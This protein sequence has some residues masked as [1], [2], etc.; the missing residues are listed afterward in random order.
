MDDVARVAKVSRAT[1]SRVLN[2]NHLVEASTRDRVRLAMKEVG[3]A[4]SKRRSGPKPKNARPSQ[5]DRGA[6]A[7]ITIGATSSLFQDPIMISVMDKLQESC[8]ERQLNLLLDQ[9]TSLEDIPLCIQNRQVDGAILMVAGRPAYQREAIARLAKM[10]PCVQLFSPGHSVATVDHATV[11]DVAVGAM[12]YRTLLDEGCRQFAV[13]SACAW[14]HEA[15]L[16][17]GRAYLDRVQNEGYPGLCFAKQ[18]EP[19]SAE[20]VWPQPLNVFESMTT[21]AQ[22]IAKT[23]ASK[24]DP[25]GVFLTLDDHAGALHEALDQE[26]LLREEAVKLVVAGTTPYNVETLVP[27]PLLIDLGFPDL[28]RT[29]VDRLIHRAYN[30]Q[31]DSLTFKVAPKLLRPE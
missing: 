19:G 17:R 23:G 10:L 24:K 8:R 11:N 7:L 21:V 26:G 5:L 1:V 6:I 4:P 28:I 18:M 27:Q 16:V 14:F 20:R 13:V 22:A 25:I 12:A 31:S 9:M 30:L 2:D 15:L 29:S 3:Y